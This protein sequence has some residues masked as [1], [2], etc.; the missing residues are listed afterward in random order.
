VLH[1][2][3]TVE[4][5]YVLLLRSPSPITIKNTHTHIFISSSSEGEVESLSEGGQGESVGC[6]E[7]SWI[8]EIRQ[9]DG[10]QGVLVETL[11][12]IE[13]LLSTFSSENKESFALVTRREKTEVEICTQT[14]VWVSFCCFS[15]CVF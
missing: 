3:N 14:L 10:T 12:Q 9:S 2:T 11:D 6:R 5:L 8:V 1:N 4:T 15:H 7:G 13:E